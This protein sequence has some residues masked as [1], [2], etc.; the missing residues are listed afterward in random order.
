MTPAAAT[1]SY[2]NGRAA[3]NAVD[4][5]CIQDV[6]RGDQVGARVRKVGGAAAQMEYR[7]AG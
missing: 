6:A 3:C 5:L 1:G 4:R 7:P 2:A